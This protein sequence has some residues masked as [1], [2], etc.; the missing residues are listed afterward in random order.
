[1]FVDQGAVARFA[2]SRKSRRAT[3]VN[4]SSNLATGGTG[5]RGGDGT[6]A[7]GGGGGKQALG[8]GTGGHGGDGYGGASARAEPAAGARAA[9]S[10]I[11]AARLSRA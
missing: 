5:G 1:M 3:G 7:Q 6:Y 4:F 11:R 9:D 10:S 8:G 2:T